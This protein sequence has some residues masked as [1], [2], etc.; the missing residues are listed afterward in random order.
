MPINFPSSP[1]VGQVY[2]SGSRSWEWS[3]TAWNA[4]NMA[5]G[6]VSL[7]FYNSSGTVDNIALVNGN[8][9]PFYKSDGTQDNINIV[10][11]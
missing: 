8:A 4:K 10:T 9:L 7:P 6:G 11:A 2:T 1:T 3:G 5:V